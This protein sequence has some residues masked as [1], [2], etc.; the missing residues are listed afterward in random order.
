[1]N[2]ALLLLAAALILQAWSVGA[3]SRAGS[4]SL[5]H[6]RQG[7]AAAA[8]AGAGVASPLL[9]RSR[10]LQQEAPVDPATLNNFTG[11]SRR[12]GLTER[13]NCRRCWQSA[14][15]PPALLAGVPVLPLIGPRSVLVALPLMLALSVSIPLGCFFC[16]HLF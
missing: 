14:R 3:P 2:G 12:D 5:G 1:M 9:P 16:C 6:Q 10:A 15:P 13:Q 4:S 11:E 7:A 8:A